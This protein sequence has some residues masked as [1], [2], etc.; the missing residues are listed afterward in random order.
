MRALNGEAMAR[1]ENGDVKSGLALLAESRALVEDDGFSDIDRAEVLY[2]LGVVPV[3]AGEHLDGGRALRRGA[4]P[5]G[6]LGRC[7]PTGC[8]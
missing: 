6:A 7:R 5:R 8:A 1:A 4:R 2:R 3:P